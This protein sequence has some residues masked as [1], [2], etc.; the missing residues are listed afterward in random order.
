MINRVPSRLLQRK[1]PFQLLNNSL[2][3]Y[4]NLKVFDSLCYA[5]TLPYNRSN[6]QPRATT[7]VFISYPQGMKAYKL[8]NIDQENFFISRDVT[9][10][11]DI[12]PFKN[13][14]TPQHMEDPLLG[15]SLLKASHDLP[16]IPSKSP[17]NTPTPPSP[18]TTNHDN[19]TKATIQPQMTY[20]HQHNNLH[21]K[22]EPLKFSEIFQ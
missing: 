4:K 14:P 7:A 16:N 6:F 20:L 21:L 15:F 11:E 12:F 9:F 22:K 19:T 8:Y 1:S 17:P 10:H 3:D 13:L 5:F 18:I 2:P